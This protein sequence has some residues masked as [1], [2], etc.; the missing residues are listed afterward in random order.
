MFI[1]RIV[2]ATFVSALTI[3]GVAP[4]ASA[5]KTSDDSSTVKVVKTQPTKPGGNYQNR[6]DWD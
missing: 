5:A 2:A 4:A 1:K 3:V 6:I